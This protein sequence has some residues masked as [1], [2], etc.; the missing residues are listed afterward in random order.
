[1][2]REKL[3][4]VGR[5]VLPRRVKDWLWD[6]SHLFV[7]PPVGRVRL[8]SLRRTNPIS[9]NFGYE[10]GLPIDRHYIELFLSEH[11]DDV[12]GAALEFQDD[13]YLRRFGGARV[14][15]TD[16]MNLERDYPGTTIA[17]D[18][19]V[20]DGLPTERFDCIVCT[21]VV[22]LVYDLEAAVRNLHG[23]LRPEGVLLVTMPGITRIARGDGWEDQWRLTTDSAH[24][25]FATRF[26][27]DRVDVRAYG[28]PLSAAGFLMGL[29]TRDLKPAELDARHP[30]FEVIVAV[31]AQRAP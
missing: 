17:A 28:N 18:V 30:D 22:Q 20:G 14:T 5:Q 23:M 9:P 4:G 10:R 11:S 21:G 8:G 13:A 25:L 24:K 6:H 27:H 15:T 26:G 3:R 16:V 2:N 12:R 31:R 7:W 29:A 19:A 1:V